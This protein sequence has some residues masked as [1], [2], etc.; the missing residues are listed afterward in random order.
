ML[1]RLFYMIFRD[2]LSNQNKH[3]SDT[4]YDLLKNIKLSIDFLLFT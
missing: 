3:K 4:V 1:F 2:T